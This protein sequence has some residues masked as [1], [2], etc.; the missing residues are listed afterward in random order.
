[1]TTRLQTL[2]FLAG[3]LFASGLAQA[4]E[5][6]PKTAGYFKGQDMA[7]AG[8]L[9]PLD[10][11]GITSA[12]TTSLGDPQRGR[13]VMV[14]SQKGNCIACHRVAALSQEPSHGD[15]GPSLNSVGLRYTEPQ[16]RQLVTN[17]RSFFPNTVM[18]GYYVSEGLERVPSA[19]A[20]KTI[21]SP[22][23]V[24]DVV[25]FLKTLR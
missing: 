14:D 12:L 18:P 8:A 22:T 13:V 10:L 16:L 5:C 20:G 21:L 9:S 6:R 3:A 17:P 4:Q 11:K 1:M 24:E 7:A 19:F 2:L 25:A 23:E 15:L